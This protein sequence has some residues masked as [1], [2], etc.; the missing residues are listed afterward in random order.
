MSCQG[1]PQLVQDKYEPSSL[2]L[3]WFIW[4]ELSGPI[5]TGLFLLNE[6]VLLSFVG[7]A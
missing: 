6:N 3:L 7:V 4:C 2:Q 1:Y 5:N